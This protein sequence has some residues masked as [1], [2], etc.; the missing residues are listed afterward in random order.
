MRRR[1]GPL[2]DAA[3]LSVIGLFAGFLLIVVAL[4]LLPSIDQVITDLL[5]KNLAT[6]GPVE[7]MMIRLIPLSLIVAVLAG[8]FFFARPQL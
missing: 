6:I 7:E 8:I 4:A 3:Q 5:G 1:R 2:G